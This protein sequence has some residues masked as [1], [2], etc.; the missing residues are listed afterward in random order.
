MWAHGKEKVIWSGATY[1]PVLDVVGGT[2]IRDNTLILN[3]AMTG[4]GGSIADAQIARQSIMAMFVGQPYSKWL[5]WNPLDKNTDPHHIGSGTLPVQAVIRTPVADARPTPFEDLQDKATQG[6]Y[7]RD[8]A[9]KDPVYKLCIQCRHCV[10]YNGLEYQ[11]PVEHQVRH[12]THYRC[13]HPHIEP[14]VCMVTGEK[15]YLECSDV[16]NDLISPC[17]SPGMLW[18]AKS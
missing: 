17:S 1:V 16:R 2:S 3:V 15:T 6:D 10:L 12:I 11:D 13:R 8:A 18:E 14:D 9:I 5:K 7:D 4:D